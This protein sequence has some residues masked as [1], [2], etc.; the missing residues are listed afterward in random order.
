MGDS[1]TEQAGN[2]PDDPAAEAGTPPSQD[3]AVVRRRESARQPAAQPTL[4]DVQAWEGYRVD[5]VEGQAVAR[6]EGAFVDGKSGDPVWV[7]VRLGRFGRIVPISIRECAAAA[8]RVWVPHDR[9]VIRNA[10]AV[11]PGQPLT[12]EQEKQVLDYYGIPEGVGRSVE[13]KDRDPDRVTAK[14]VAT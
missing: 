11:D 13:I 9:E 1:E 5:D 14:P 12:G 6:V 4:E 2:G 10:P 7:L 8:G 3:P